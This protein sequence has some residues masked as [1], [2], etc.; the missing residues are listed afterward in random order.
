MSEYDQQR[1]FA[2][3]I[4]VLISYVISNRVTGITP[5]TLDLNLKFLAQIGSFFLSL[6][7]FYEKVRL[8]INLQ[9]S[10]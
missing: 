7:I 1:I 9:K 10:F 3:I 2:F 8:H 6:L 5:A 4:A